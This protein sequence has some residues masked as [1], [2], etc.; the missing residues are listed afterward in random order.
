[1][2]G[3]ARGLGL[4]LW[5]LAA[6]ALRLGSTH[7]PPPPPSQLEACLAGGCRAE[8]DRRAAA[9]PLQLLQLLRWTLMVLLVALLAEARILLYQ[10]S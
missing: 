8:Q 7:S 4:T 3:S 9:E 1:M 2:G 10:C 5:P 6:A